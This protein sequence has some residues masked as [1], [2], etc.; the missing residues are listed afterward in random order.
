MMPSQATS[1]PKI[2][3]QAAW[4]VGCRIVG[5]VCTFVSNLL[6]ARLLGPE[7]FGAF[8]IATTVLSFGCLI[9]LSG[10]SEAGLRF[11]SENLGMRRNRV[12]STYL[13]T[14]LCWAGI[15]SFIASGILAIFLIVLDRFTGYWD[16][17]TKP[18]LLMAI[19]VL[20]LTWQ[21]LSAQLLRGLNDLRSASIYS[22]GQTGGPL[23]N[24]IFLIPLMLAAIWLIPLKEVQVIGLLVGSIC[25]TLPFALWKLFR[26]GRSLLGDRECEQSYMLSSEEKRELAG[27]AGSMLGI[28]MLAFVTVQSDIWI[29]GAMLESQGFGFYGAVKRSQL[30]AHMPIQMALMTV[31]ASIPRMYVQGRLEELEKNFRTAM[32]WAAI[33]SILSLIIFAIF[34]VQVL[35]AIFGESYGGAANIVLPLS[36]GLAALIFFG[37][38]ADV[39]AITGNHR[40]VLR[41]NVF[42]RSRISRVAFLELTWRVLSG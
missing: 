41:V 17:A 15:T 6:V 35:S 34:P 30:V 5:I 26:T 19:G 33:P 9:A 27:V 29:G 25:V 23:S 12:A 32:T 21:Q 28:Q 37:C 16:M 36:V 1:Q 38:P 39:L 13:K 3:H 42:L 20:V 4:V 7:G 24:L 10:L 31:Q 14:T 22:G 11:I 18:M 8:L 2:S 40:L